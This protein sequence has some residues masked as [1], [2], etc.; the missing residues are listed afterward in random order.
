MTQT[1]FALGTHDTNVKVF[2]M[3][4]LYANVKASYTNVKASLAMAAR[5]CYTI[6]RQLKQYLVERVSNVTLTL[7]DYVWHV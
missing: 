1:T 3:L 7:Q 2:G 6:Y 5:V 4:L